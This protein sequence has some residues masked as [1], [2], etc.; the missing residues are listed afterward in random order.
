MSQDRK[1]H[2]IVKERLQLNFTG[3][4]RCMQGSKIPGKTAANVPTNQHSTVTI[5]RS[6]N[7]N[8]IINRAAILCKIE[9]LDEFRSGHSTQGI[10][11]CDGYR[12]EKLG[13]DVR[14]K[15]A[16]KKWFYRIQILKFFL[17]IYIEKKTY[18]KT[19]ITKKRITK[20]VLKRPKNDLSLTCFEVL[21]V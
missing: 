2:S 21:M 6:Q 12:N 3:I 8:R 16:K 1:N 13:R 4:L 17:P 19:P 20:I 10:C 14:K 5:I 11:I 9:A 18:K 7:L 15:N